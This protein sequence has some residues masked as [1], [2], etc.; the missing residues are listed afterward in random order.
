MEF[1]KPPLEFV[2]QVQKLR[3]RGLSV[4][5]PDKASFY[6][7]QIN[8]YRFGTYCWTFFADHNSHQFLPGTTFEQVLDL[9]IFD[10][11]LRLL[12]LDAIERIEISVRTQWA[13]HLSHFGGAHAHLEKQNFNLKVFSHQDFIDQLQVELRRTTEPNIQRQLRKY[14]EQ[15]PAVWICSEVLSFGWLSKAV[16]GLARRRLKQDIADNYGL[17]ESVLTSVLHHLVNV[18]NIS[19]HHSR[20]WNRDFTITTKLPTNGEPKTI[21]SLNTAKPRELYNTLVLIAHVMNRIAPDNQWRQ[22]LLDLLDRYPAIDTSAMGFPA[23]WR[24]LAIWQL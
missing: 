11:E 23:D 12:V 7:S 17:N 5:C 14:D 3:E 22:R 19:A 13:Y 15:T 21:S 24:Q 6:L 20:L 2:H 9:Y 16:S 1:A 4:T 10:R 18:R 8:Y